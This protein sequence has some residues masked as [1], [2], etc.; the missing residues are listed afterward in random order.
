MATVVMQTPVLVLNATYE[1]VHITAVKRAIVLVLKGV[2]R[3]EE[4][5][6]A[7]IRSAYL[8]LQVPSVIRLLEYRRIPFQSRA[9]SRRNILLRDRNS[10]QYC[11]EVFPSGEL[12][13]DH[14]LPRSKG[15]TTSWDNLVASC[16][17]CNNIK[18]DQTPEEA[19]L[20]LIRRPRPYNLHTNRHL[21]RQL[22]RAEE[23]WRKYL[24][25]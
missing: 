2:A 17:R 15:G 6:H 9:L 22:G 3:T 24:F 18:G 16:H 5:N 13:L 12:T 14:V 7:V 11:G 20:T 4:E 21:M 1:P 23:R 8:S 19:G 25:Y 10:C